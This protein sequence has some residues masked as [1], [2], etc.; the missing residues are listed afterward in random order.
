MKSL[1]HNLTQIFGI[2]HK[3][4]FRQCVLWK[5]KLCQDAM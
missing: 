1:Q 3:C 4:F 5:F 2:T